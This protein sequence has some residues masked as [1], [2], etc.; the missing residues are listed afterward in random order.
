MAKHNDYPANRGI[1]ARLECILTGLS[2]CRTTLQNIHFAL[3]YIPAGKLRDTIVKQIETAL[4]AAVL[5]LDATT[6][7]E[8]GK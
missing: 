1:R 5:A 4:K 2:L 7:D 3:D 8:E 6:G